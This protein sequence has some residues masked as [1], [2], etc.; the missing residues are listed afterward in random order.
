MIRLIAT[1]LDN[2]LLNKESKVPEET[3]RLLER[4]AEKGVKVAVAT[5]RS[6]ASAKAIADQLGQPSPAICYNGAAVIDTATGEPYFM[7]CLAPDLVR[8][9]LAFARESDLY[10]QLYDK[11]EIV[12]EKLRLDRHPDPDLDY[13]GYREVGDFRE[14]ELFGTP[15]ILLAAPPER[16]PGIQS[17]LEA[18]YGRRAY[19]AQSES[20]LVEVMNKGC[21]KGSALKRLREILGLSKEEVMGCGDNTND[22]PLLLESGTAVA[23]ANSVPEL[24]AAA[25]YVCRGE[26]SEGFNEAVKKFVLGGE[27]K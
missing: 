24:K 2:T 27:E 4:A 13:A 18:L 1:D 10:V 9:I 17:K 22:L 7:D 15:K 11:D 14:I 6:F 16:I 21:D 5:G 26:R 19:F 20:H 3:V 25:T 12:V 23:V 8:D